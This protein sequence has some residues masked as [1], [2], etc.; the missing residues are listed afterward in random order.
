QYSSGNA[1]VRNARSFMGEQPSVLEDMSGGHPDRVTGPMVTAA[2][3]QGDLVARRAFA[4]VGDWLGIGTAN[5]VA[6]LDPE[7]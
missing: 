7:V 6:A 3:E 5:L 2:A 1:L 4:S